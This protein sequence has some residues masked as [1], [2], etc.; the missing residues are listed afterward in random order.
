[1]AVADDIRQALHDAIGWQLSL[2]DAHAH[3][4]D[5]V[6]DEA[7][8]QVKRYRAILKRR[9]GTSSTPMERAFANAKPVGLDDLMKMKPNR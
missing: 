5:G 2:A 9:Y 7:R 6:S 8:A 1:M 4:D 3:C